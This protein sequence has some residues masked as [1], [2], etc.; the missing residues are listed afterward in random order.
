MRNL[1]NQPKVSYNNPPNCNK[2]KIYKK[3]KKDDLKKKFKK[4][5]LN[6]KNV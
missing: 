6:I 4:K 2:N 3:T 5:C 1:I